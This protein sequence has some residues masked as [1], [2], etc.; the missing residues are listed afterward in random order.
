MKKIWLF[1]LSFIAI[2]WIWVSFANPIAAPGELHTQWYTPAICNMLRNV[3][4]DNYKAVILSSDQSRRE[5]LDWLP[6]SDSSDGKRKF[7]APKTNACI[8]KWGTIF[9]VD[10]SIKIKNI[11]PYNV[12]DAWSIATSYCTSNCDEIRIFKIINEWNEYKIIYVKSQ[13][14]HDWEIL[15]VADIQWWKNLSKFFIA[16]VMAI[17]IETII[18]FII[19]KLFQK[20]DKISNRKLILFWILPTTIT[21]PFLWF[22]LPLIIKEW[23]W[24]RVSWELLVTI[25]EAI[26]IKYWLKISRW[27][28][29]LASIVCNAASYGAW[30]LIFYFW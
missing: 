7:Y 24:Y 16:W 30:L 29:I 5:F 9:L 10:K 23:L 13:R 3:E 26:I 19:A 2:L 25:I 18:L 14:K 17:I 11:T 21:L 4:I 6:N 12:I 28:A 22:I 27:K 8:E 20:E 15:D 1:I